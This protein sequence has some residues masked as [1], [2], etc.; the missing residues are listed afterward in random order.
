MA[1]L[2]YVICTRIGAVRAV[3]DALLSGHW[4]RSG[5]HHLG[6]VACRADYDL[7]RHI[8]W[9]DHVGVSDRWWSLLPDLHG[10]SAVVPYRH[11]L[12]LWLGIHHGSCF[13][14]ALGQF[15]NCSVFRRVHQHLHRRRRQP[16]LGCG[17]VPG[18]LV[19]PC[20]HVSVQCSFISGE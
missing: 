13:N 4:R 2:L 3:V 15:W 7:R 6:L 5:G 12:D 10:V 1:G 20:Y 16:N 11:R 18:L 14:N 17:N 8:P 9:R 19:V